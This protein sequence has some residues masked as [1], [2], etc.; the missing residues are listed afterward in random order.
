MWKNAFPSGA[1]VDELD[2][3][4]LARFTL[5]GGNVHSVAVNSA[6]LAARTAEE[7]ITMPLVLEAV[8]TEFRKLER[9]VNEAEFRWLAPAGATA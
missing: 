8:R 2:Y 5:T 9:P 4:R 7:T 1:R 6:F 3:D